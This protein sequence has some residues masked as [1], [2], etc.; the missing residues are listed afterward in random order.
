MEKVYSELAAAIEAC[1]SDKASGRILVG[2]AGPPGSGKSTIAAN[3]VD[4]LNAPSRSCRAQAIS[5]DGFHYT[6]KYLDTMPDPEEAHRRRGSPWTFDVDGILA[7]VKQLHDSSECT[8]RERAKILAP[9]FDH[10]LKDPKT[11]D[12]VISPDTS[13]VVLDGNYLLLDWPGWKEI[14]RLLDMKI[15]VN[16]EPSTARKR[17]AKRH[18]L[19]GIEPT[20]ERGIERFDA[21]DLINGKLIRECLVPYDIGV[22]SISK[23]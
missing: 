22:E 12:I 6:R 3:V 19:S 8:A 4:I 13:I 14:H 16:V 17:V 2:I 11:N 7:F 5:L 21:N 15:F 10:A 1:A 9:S 18:L 20:L 23:N